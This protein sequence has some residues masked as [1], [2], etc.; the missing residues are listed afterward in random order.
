M[1]RITAKY[2]D[3]SRALWGHGIWQSEDDLA[4]WT[5]EA[6]GY[7]C[8]VIRIPEGGW[9]CGYVVLPASHRLSGVEFC[10]LPMGVIDSCHGGVNFSDYGGPQLP[11]ARCWATTPFPLV[12]GTDDW[13]LGFHCQQWRDK[14]PRFP[15][16]DTT[17]RDQGYVEEQCKKLAAALKA[18]ETEEENG[19][20]NP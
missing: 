16:P 8:L 20:D 7:T 12:T 3:E 2:S 13:V 1:E 14:M 9:L 15:F 18:A 5:D 4:A 6:T 19:A 17:Y 10:D 11:I